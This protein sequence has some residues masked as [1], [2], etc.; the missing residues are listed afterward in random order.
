MLSR[1]CASC[2]GPSCATTRGAIGAALLA[3]ALGVA[4]A[5]SVQLINQSALGEFAPAVRAVNGEPDFELRAPAQRLRRGA[6]RRAS[7]AHPQ[8]DD[9][10]P[11][12]RDRHA[13]RFD[14]EGR[15]RRR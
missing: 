15:A 5:F 6:V 10:E 11:G 14:R 8:V 13:T 9:R 1:C 3:V 4:L 12:D 7:R 2:R